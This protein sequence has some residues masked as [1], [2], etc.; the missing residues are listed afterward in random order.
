M[1]RTHGLI[2]VAMLLWSAGAWADNQ[3]GIPAFATD[4]G[5][6]VDTNAELAGNL[7][8]YCNTTTTSTITCAAGTISST[9][10]TVTSASCFDQT[11]GLVTVCNTSGVCS[12]AAYAS[13]S[14]S[15]L[16]G[17]T[18]LPDGSLTACSA[19]F[20]AGASVYALTAATTLA[21]RLNV[22]QDAIQLTQAAV[23]VNVVSAASLGVSTCAAAQTAIGSTQKTTFRIDTNLNCAATT[24]FTSNITLQ[25]QGGLLDLDVTAN[26]LTIQGPVD[27]QPGQQLFTDT[28]I[29][30]VRF[31]GQAVTIFPEIFGGTDWG[32]QLRRA[33]AACPTGY[34]CDIDMRNIAGG[35]AASSVSISASNIHVLF[36]PY[37]YTMTDPAQFQISGPAAQ[38]AE[39]IELAGVD[40]STTKLSCNMNGGCLAVVGLLAT[41][42]G[43]A[44]F[45]VQNN[46][47]VGDRTFTALSG[48]LTGAGL[49]VG[50]QIKVADWGFI[51][52]ASVPDHQ[53]TNDRTVTAITGTT[54][55]V[56]RPFTFNFNTQGRTAWEKYASG[57]R[58]TFVH[59]LTIENAHATTGR[60]AYVQYALDFRMEHVTLH[61]VGPSAN[62]LMALYGS[63]NVVLRHNTFISALTNG[64][65]SLEYAQTDGG[66]I[67]GNR[68]MC[69]VTGNAGPGLLLDFGSNYIVVDSNIFDC[70]AGTVTASS[71]FVSSADN[72]I[73]VNNQISGNRL[74]HYG[75]HVL[76]NNN[77]LR[78]NTTTGFAY[79]VALATA[80]YKLTGLQLTTWRPNYVYGAEACITESPNNGW[81]F[82]TTA[83]GTSGATQPTWNEVASVKA[84]IPA[85]GATTTDGTVTWF[86]GPYHTHTGTVLEG[87]KNY[88]AQTGGILIG[89]G[90][91]G[92]VVKNFTADTDTGKS[93]VYANSTSGAGSSADLITSFPGGAN[94]GQRSEGAVTQFGAVGVV[95]ALTVDPLL[96][97][98]SV[99]A[100]QGPGTCSTCATT[101][102]YYV[103]A[104]PART[105]GRETAATPVLLASQ[106]ALDANHKN[107]ITWVPVEGAAC[108]NV[109]GRTSGSELRLASCHT[110]TTFTDTGTITPA[111]ASPP[112]TNKTGTLV[113]V[114]AQY[115]VAT[116]PTYATTVLATTP[117]G[118]WRMNEASGNLADSSGN[119]NTATATGTGLTYQVAGSITQSSD[120]A[121]SLPGTSPNRW[122]TGAGASL[123]S[124]DV[125][126][127]AFAF[128]KAVDG[129]T[130][131]ILQQ[132]A[133]GMEIALVT[134]NQMSFGKAAVGNITTSTTTYTGT[135][136]HYCVITKN[137]ATT[138]MYIDGVE[139]TGTVTDR[140]ISPVDATLYFGVYYDGVTS[141]YNGSLDELAVWRRALSSTEART[142]YTQWSNAKNGTSAYATDCVPGS[143][144]ALGGGSGGVALYEQGRWA[145]QPTSPN[146]TFGVVSA[147]RLKATLGT[148]LGAGDFA[149]SAGFGSTAAASSVTGTD[150]RWQ[151]TFTSSGTGQAANPTATLTFK[152]GTFTT[153][154]IYWVLPNGGTGTG[155][156][157]FTW[158]ASAT[159]LTL[160]CYG[161]PVNAETYILVGGSIG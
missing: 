154:P 103:S 12:N 135:A 26:A 71:I 28:A 6:G 19:N 70:I 111:G 159:A 57:P 16:N 56:D 150:Q 139:V 24:T 2:L 60:A 45:V 62:N 81:I 78:D 35:T 44:Q 76:G 15:T 84:G 34:A 104:L 85:T 39:G 89:A 138:H 80:A 124:G 92:S 132:K 7:Q 95:G 151:A 107:T 77:I 149:F 10:F 147:Q 120:T 116:L 66:L 9:S 47:A 27:C 144:P 20:A 99:A 18:D 87:H 146:P 97:P 105:Q 32:V 14:G 54:V 94:G 157:G 40:Q 67:Y 100:T 11:G 98:R 82:C 86:G 125:F 145:C 8:P 156:V 130:M 58:G 109:Y 96:A 110:G 121:V 115:T 46:I 48:D 3:P 65:A 155:C 140:T 142:L 52:G 129:T 25:C 112:T 122:A 22:L 63:R 51:N 117:G 73:L 74:T 148:A 118:Y 108:Y 119:S 153:P 61:S 42:G 113:S 126:T 114:P 38:F 53:T 49:T 59:D 102:S 37:T 127:A 90:V 4:S 101:F 72:N 79:G 136:W 152:D 158:S 21:P 143:S 41:V 91:S 33:I 160:T 75:I 137:G 50:D 141:P 64:G 30:S 5:I 29:D 36:G 17:V 128:K 43:I 134:A 31:S 68:F 161:T 69:D 23:G 13:I 93:I 131:R 83:G 1:R 123:P 55:T 88:G 133:N 106:D